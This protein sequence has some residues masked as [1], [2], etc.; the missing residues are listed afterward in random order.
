MVEELGSSTYATLYPIA[1]NT[2][3]ITKEQHLEITGLV[4]DA[5]A[6][7]CDELLLSGEC[8][9]IVNECLSQTKLA[10]LHDNLATSTLRSLQNQPRNA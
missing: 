9:W 8:V 5:I 4:E 6:H 7:L 2:M 3:E 10:K 1:R